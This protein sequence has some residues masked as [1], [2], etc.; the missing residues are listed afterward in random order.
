MSFSQIIIGVVS[1]VSVRASYFSI[2]I[3]ELRLLLHIKEV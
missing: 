1:G 3:V 2:S